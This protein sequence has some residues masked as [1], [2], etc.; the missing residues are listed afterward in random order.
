MPQSLLG[1]PAVHQ[2]RA[3]D[4]ELTLCFACDRDTSQ[5]LLKRW[6]AYPLLCFCNGYSSL[7]QLREDT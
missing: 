4:F 2:S 3:K 6:L 5:A 1:L 7:L